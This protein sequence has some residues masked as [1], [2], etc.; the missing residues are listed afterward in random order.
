MHCNLELYYIFL[1]TETASDDDDD[2]DRIVFKAYFVP[3]LR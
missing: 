3:V 1:P 2:D